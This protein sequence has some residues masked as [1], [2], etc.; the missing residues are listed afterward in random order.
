MRG[1]QS[2]MV[3]CL[4][5]PIKASFGATVGQIPANCGMKKLTNCRLLMKVDPSH[6][7]PVKAWSEACEPH[8]EIAGVFARLEMEQNSSLRP[9][10]SAD[11][12]ICHRRTVAVVFS[13]SQSGKKFHLAQPE[14]VLRANFVTALGFLAVS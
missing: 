6:L 1:R 10:G 2:I 13:V 12:Q 8:C 5:L 3:Y 4:C 7:H 11:L 14:K 9:L